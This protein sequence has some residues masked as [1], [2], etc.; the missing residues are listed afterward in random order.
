VGV[1]ILGA[2]V[3]FFLVRLALSPLKSIERVATWV[4]HGRFGERVPVSI[5][6]DRELARLS[7]T[8][9]AML[10]TL[11]ADRK[12][13]ENLGVKEGSVAEEEGSQA[14]RP[15]RGASDAGITREIV[16]SS[17]VG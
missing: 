2:T 15:W 14:T 17:D 12:R 1:L 6:A 7:R 16:N 9:N 8:I 10:D 11:A 3:N 13:F 4:S 5:V